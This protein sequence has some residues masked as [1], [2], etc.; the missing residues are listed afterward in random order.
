M[1]FLYSSLSVHPCTKRVL[2]RHLHISPQLRPQL[3][4]VSDN[5]GQGAARIVSLQCLP[6]TSF[7]IMLAM[8]NI[9]SGLTNHG[10]DRQESS[11]KG[12][13]LPESRQLLLRSLYSLLTL[14]RIDFVILRCKSQ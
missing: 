13:T 7:P 10:P 3:L 5:A 1:V 12:P 4:E 9:S 14:M 6:K 11:A 2:L 8:V